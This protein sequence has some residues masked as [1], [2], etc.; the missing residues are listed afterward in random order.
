M[1]CVLKHKKAELSIV[2][3]L[4]KYA[5]K[6]AAHIHCEPHN[7]NKK[8][9]EI[10]TQARVPQNENSLIVNIFETRR[11]NY[12]THYTFRFEFVY[13]VYHEPNQRNGNWQT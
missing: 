5:H 7:S 11:M 13:T 12:K 6:R 10:Y 4:K 9:N 2:Y 1:L 3:E 8:Q